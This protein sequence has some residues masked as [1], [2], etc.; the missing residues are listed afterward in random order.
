MNLYVTFA[1][2][3]SFMRLDEALQVEIATVVTN[4]PIQGYPE[5]HNSAVQMVI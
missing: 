1:V 3:Q 2:F 5:K 4:A